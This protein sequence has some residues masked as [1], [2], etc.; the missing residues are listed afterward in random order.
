MNTKDD[1]RPA[2]EGIF[3]CFKKTTKKDWY[4]VLEEHN[5]VVNK[6]SV[7]LRDLMFGDTGKLINRMF[8][9]DMGLTEEDDTKNVAQPQP[10]D[11]AMINKIYEK[12]VS[13]RKVTYQ[14]SPAIEYT[15]ILNEDE[16]NGTGSQLITEYGLVNELDEL[17]AKKNRAAIYKDGETSL[18]FVWTI[19]FN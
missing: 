8:Y 19:V 2:M 5:L 15:T 7:I 4:L 1:T 16:C 14:E 3:Q 12:A 9:G 10:T 18:K 6:A 17:F 11:T 13:K